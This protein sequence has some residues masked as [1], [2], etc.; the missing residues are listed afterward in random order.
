MAKF[1]LQV[2][3]AIRIC[4]PLALLIDLQVVIV[5][6]YGLGLVW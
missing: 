6:L 2:H 5:K 4:I 3:P 1:Q